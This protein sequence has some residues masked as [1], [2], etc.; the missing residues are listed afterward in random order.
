V[1]FWACLYRGHAEG[2]FQID[3]AVAND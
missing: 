3:M 1:S 2:V